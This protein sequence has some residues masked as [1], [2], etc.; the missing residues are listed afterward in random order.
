MAFPT[1]VS[2]TAD[3]YH[4]IG[5]PFI[6][7]AGNV[8][9]VSR[10][11][12]ASDIA[13]WK[14]ADP[15]TSF[16]AA[17]TLTVTS[18]NT[19]RAIN[20]YQVSDVLHIVTRDAAA[21][22]SN[23][24]RYHTFNMA[25]DAFVTSNELVK[26]TYT[27]KGTVDESMVGIVIR[28]DA[29]KII[30]YE[31]PQVL[32]DVQRARTYYA[33]YLGAAWTADFALDNG[34]NVDWYPQELVLG[35]ADR[36]HFFFLDYTT[37]DLYQRTLTSANALETFP[38]AFD[39]TVVQQLDLGHQR[40]IAYSASAGGTIIRYPYFNSFDNDI[41][42][43]TFTSSDAPTPVVAADITGA[44]DPE[45]IRRVSSLA[46]DGNVIYHTFTNN[47]LHDIYIQSSIDAAAWSA[48]SIFLTASAEAI[49][50]NIY[51][52]GALKVVAIVHKNAGDG[53]RYTEYTLS[54]SVGGAQPLLTL[55]LLGCGR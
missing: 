6:S 45:G 46:K 36:T 37:A 48:P 15:E 20:A 31:G 28:S 50:T 52:R 41:S 21:T 34:G 25:T 35:S 53:L 49:F 40:P 18:G 23:Q 12:T 2:S 51:T 7:S 47:T 17:A 44:T 27:Q 38:A 24:I 11:T 9:I 29:S 32:A 19:I 5:G 3:P 39:T 13:V 8:Y 30:L 42:E 26:T 33:R 55:S 4:G 1:V 14:A 16:S 43:A 22:N 54:T 10:S